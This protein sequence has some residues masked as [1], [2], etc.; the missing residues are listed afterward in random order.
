MQGLEVL[1]CRR[2]RS[3]AISLLPKNVSVNLGTE[4]MGEEDS[5]LKK[6][7]FLQAANNIPLPKEEGFDQVQI[8][9][10]RAHHFFLKKSA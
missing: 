10:N 4:N 3:G 9:P 5:L 8:L 2:V 6:P 1:G 7:A